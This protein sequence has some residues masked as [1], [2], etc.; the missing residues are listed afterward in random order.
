MLQ[1]LLSVIFFPLCLLTLV[2][3][4]LVWKRPWHI[5]EP[6]DEALLPRDNG[7]VMASDSRQ[8]VEDVLNVLSGRVEVQA[9][10]A[11]QYGQ[12]LEQHRD[13]LQKA[14]SMRSIRE[15]EQLLL[16]EVDAMRRANESYRQQLDTANRT[17]NEQKQRLEKLTLDATLDF[18]TQVPNRRAFDKRL[19]EEIERFRRGGPPFCLALLDIDHFKQINDT[20][21]HPAGDEV[22]RRTARLL[23]KNRRITD[24]VARFGGEEFAMLLPGSHESAASVLVDRIREMMSELRFPTGKNGE[25]IGISFSAGIAEM[26]PADQGT[27]SLIQ[28]ADERLYRAKH[29][30]RNRV[31]AN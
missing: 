25:T 10:D 8:L 30:G 21:G 12:V 2:L 5:P 26:L 29:S 19:R 6:R 4:Y 14:Q 24:F 23:D 17:I 16:G 28:R 18:L 13:A 20:H 27:A 7:P 9:R 15:V 1:T 31:V 3:A 11:R 22:L